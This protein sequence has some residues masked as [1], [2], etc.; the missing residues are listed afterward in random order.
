MIPI[1]H[2]A[3]PSRPPEAGIE[4]RSGKV[5]SRSKTTRHFRFRCRGWRKIGGDA[6]DDG[7]KARG[8]TVFWSASRYIAINS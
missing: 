5:I 7:A 6:E 3:F 8:F 1:S 4:L 2:T